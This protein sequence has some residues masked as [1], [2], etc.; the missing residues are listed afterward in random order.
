[1]Q[2]LERFK[3]SHIDEQIAVDGAVVVDEGDDIDCFAW[4]N[5]LSDKRL[6][7]LFLF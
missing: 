4:F 7:N 3:T 2:I 6:R 5:H 1:M